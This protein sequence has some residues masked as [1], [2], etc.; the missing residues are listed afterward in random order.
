V[1]VL[2]GGALGCPLLA[3]VD[4]RGY[5]GVSYQP[6]DRCGTREAWPKS[7]GEFRP[8]V[9]VVLYGAWDVYDASFDGGRTWTSPGDPEWDAYYRQQVA[10][11]ADRLS[12]TGARLLWLTPPCFAAEPG[13]SDPDG[14][15]YD[16]SRVDVIGAID[17]Q[18]AE[19]NGM[20]I[21][22]AAHD[23]GCPVDFDAR[24][25]GVHYGDDGADAVAARLGEQITRLG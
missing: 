19:V 16:R 2:N 9:V 10:D 5:W 23:L 13:A 7:L 17:R 4:V 22:S 11:T 18:V 25:D 20:A 1:F 21:S 14:P 24:P 12:A 3:G 8:D 6:P 15:W